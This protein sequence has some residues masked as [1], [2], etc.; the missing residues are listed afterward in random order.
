MT[1]VESQL[2]HM[3]ALA[4]TPEARAGLV[5]IL[6]LAVEQRLER[7]SNTLAPRR[8]RAPTRGARAQAWW[9]AAGEVALLNVFPG[10][11]NR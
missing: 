5:E 6:N 8:N 4:R 9:D 11:D 10:W 2:S 7:E 1:N 3:I